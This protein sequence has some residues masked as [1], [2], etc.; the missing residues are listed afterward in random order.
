MPPATLLK[1]AYL[2]CFS[3]PAADRVL[4]RAIRRRRGQIRSIVELGIGKAIRSVRMIQVAQRY[5]V[6]EIRYTG[7]DLFEARPAAA[8]GMTLKRAHQYFNTLGAKIQLVPGDPNMALTRVANL[9]TGTD[10][11][12]IGSDQEAESLSQ[13]WFYVPRMI[14]ER[15]LVFQAARSGAGHKSPYRLLSPTKIAELAASARPTT[16]RAA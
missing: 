3:R 16:R 14:H 10:L 13:A 12:I 15:T 11:L 2:S 4:Y 8:P 9:L 5:A 7:I 6:G 1:Y